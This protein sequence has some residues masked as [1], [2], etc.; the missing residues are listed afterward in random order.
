MQKTLTALVVAAGVAGFVGSAFAAGCG[1]SHVAQSSKPVVT[2]DA[3][4]STPV[5]KT[6]TPET[7]KN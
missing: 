4:Q 6:T 7:A 1:Y 5:I 3:K 2:A